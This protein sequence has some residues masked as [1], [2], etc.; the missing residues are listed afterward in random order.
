MVDCPRGKRPVL[1][2]DEANAFK[3]ADDKEAKQYFL[4]VVEDHTYLSKHDKDRLI[5]VDF[6]IPFRM[7]GGRMFLVDEY[8]E[9]VA[10]SGHFKDPMD[11][12]PTQVAY[13]TLEDE[14]LGK[15]KPYDQEKS[16]GSVGFIH[17]RPLSRFSRDLLPRPLE[18]VITAQSEPALRAMEAPLKKCGKQ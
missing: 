12:E 9:Q 6:K 14:L 13:T 4:D 11:F 7:T 17:Y 15:A 10:V 1:I 3:E 8:V 5:S 2:I 16:V 18:S